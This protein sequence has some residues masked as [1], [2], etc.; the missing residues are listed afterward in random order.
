M[1]IA[2]PGSK[3]PAPLRKLR[4]RR[5]AA[6]RWSVTAGLF[7]GAAA[8]LVPYQGLGPLD[9]IWAGLFGA[10]AV[11]T[12]FRWTDYRSLAKALPAQQ[13]QLAL[14][15]TA[16]LALEAQTF[17]DGIAR[18]VR[19]KRGA[20]QFRRSAA[21]PAF[22]RLERAA[23]A[24]DGLA[25]QLAGPG[26]EAMDDVHDSQR[27]LRELAER[28]RSVEQS[29]SIAPSQ[30]RS[31]LADGHRSMVARLETGV[32]AYE[33]MVGAAASVIA[34]QSALDDVV[35]ADSVTV[36]RLSEATTRLHALA[37]GIGEMRG[38]HTPPG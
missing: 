26:R 19:R 31:S 3:V 23:Q 12:V 28:I 10:S 22:A 33:D 5:R 32:T 2:W 15:G 16:A 29:M 11:L 4:R 21:G 30:R 36:H 6:R 17:A 7:G 38:F 25:P 14:H 37:D 1:N 34:E 35:G 9:A 20:A 27:T 18:T 8:V 24:L 13:E